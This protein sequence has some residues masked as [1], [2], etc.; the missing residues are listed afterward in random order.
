MCASVEKNAIA[1][2][3]SRCKYQKHAY[4]VKWLQ[5]LGWKNIDDEREFKI[6]TIQKRLLKIRALHSCDLN[7]YVHVMGTRWRRAQG[8]A[9]DS[10]APNVLKCV[11]GALRAEYGVTV[12]QNKRNKSTHYKLNR[13]SVV[14]FDIDRTE[15]GHVPWLKQFGV[16]DV[17]EVGGTHQPGDEVDDGYPDSDDEDAENPFL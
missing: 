2:V 11:N 4:M 15:E 5:V 1:L 7:E 14:E 8:M 6:S 9:S 13:A 3:N 12:V 17:E 10:P 16:A